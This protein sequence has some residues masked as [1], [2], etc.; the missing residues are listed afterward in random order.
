MAD[1]QTSR[2]QFLREGIAASAA[3]GLIMS[4]MT[5][6]S[7]GRVIGANEKIRIGLIGCGRRGPSIVKNMLIPANANASLVA[8]CDIWKH[9]R[10]TYPGKVEK[11]FGAKPKVYSDHRK[12]LDDADVDA[13]II[14]TPAHQHCGQTIDAVQAEKHVYVEKPIAPVASDLAMLNKCYDVV[15]SSKMKVQNGSQGVS[16]PAVRA[17]KKFIASGKLG[18]LFRIESTE[19][20]PVPYW[21]HYDGP[22]T[23]AETDWKAFLY[24]RKYRPFDAHRYAKWMGYHDFSSGPICGWMSHFSNYVHYVTG[25]GFPVSCTA[26]GGKYAPGNDPRCDAPDQVSVILDYA[27]G[28]HT[29]FVTHFGSVLNSEST[30]FM[31][32]KGSLKTRFGHYIGIPTY[33]SAGVDD[34]I[35]EKPL[36]EMEQSYPGSAHMANWIDCIRNGGKPNA[37]MDFGYKQG[38][39]VLMGD[40]SCSLGRRVIFDKPKREIQPID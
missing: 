21:M 20:W 2:R 16:C 35:E 4:Q 24:N 33:S 27:E 3:T 15:K 6:A 30:V 17:V 28:F 25:C 36:L 23:E 34:T 18:K 31:F 1:V 29:Q 26:Y 40:M 19:S 22:A 13:V 14:A 39:A 10:N 5:A 12:L 38:I 11:L 32:E 7:Y 9:K 8:I 37:N